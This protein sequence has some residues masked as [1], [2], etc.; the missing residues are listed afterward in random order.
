MEDGALAFAGGTI[1]FAGPASALP[2]GSRRRAR[3]RLRAEGALATPALIDCHTHLVFAGERA[4]EF[5]LRLRGAS[6]AEIAAQGGGILATVQATRAAD[7]ETLLAAGLPR[8]LRLIESGVATL[9]VK[10]GYG[11]EPASEAKMLRV[12]RRLGDILGLTVRTSLLAA[13]ALPPEHRTDREGYLRLITERMIPE[14]AAA[15]LTDAV[16]AYLEPIAFRAEE[17]ARVF[18]AAHAHGLPV[19]LHADQLSNGGGAALAARFG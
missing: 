9:E 11:L 1:A 12:A 13:H 8:A 6:Y 10:S 7:E 3:R 18:A 5:F 16:D 15:G 17:V 4:K 2:R 14:L 19:R